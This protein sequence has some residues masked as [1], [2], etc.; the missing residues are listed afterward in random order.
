MTRRN[1]AD[2][3]RLVVTVDL[4]S[5]SFHILAARFDGGRLSVVDRLR[6]RIALAAGLDDEG[7]LT[8]EMQDAALGC[9]RRFGQRLRDVPARNVRAVGTNTLRAAKNSAQFLPR[10]ERALGHAIDVVPGREE[11]R[12][13]YLGVCHTEP[14]AAGRRLVCD[15]GGGSTE[16]TLG[17]RFDPLLAECLYMGCV[18]WTRRHFDGGRITRKRFREAR[19]AARLEVQT[20]VRTFR[21]LGWEECLGA[22]GTIRTIADALRAAGK[23]EVAGSM[24]SGGAGR[25]GEAITA[26]GLEWL[27]GRVLAAGRADR[28]KIEGI[29]DER[30]GVIAG[31]LAILMAVFDGMGIER[32][33]VAQGGLREG[34]LWDLLGRIRHEDVRDRTIRGFAA[35]YRV[36][37]EQAARVER[38]ALRLL[39][40]AAES[41]G[42]GRDDDARN[43]LAWAAQLHEV[44]LAVTYSGHHKHGAYLL[45]NSDMPGF[46][47]REQ[48][49]LSAIV[50]EHR[51][52]VAAGAFDVLPEDWRP[53]AV[54]LTLLLRLAVRLH[55]SRTSRALPR[56][57]CRFAE[58]RVSVTFPP[59]WLD[60]HP[61]TRADLEE[62]AA[63]IRGCGFTLRVK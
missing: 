12:L 53:R 60:R 62:E 21:A 43:I 4:G 55:R 18:S 5:N 7:N 25:A 31:G 52:G 20:I 49:V 29:D 9:L 46:S 17:E 6:E 3:S 14:D 32:M 56:V 58:D 44:G 30:A 36:D 2:A 26:E 63:E 10:F 33:R 24:A 13:S 38:T 59:G 40:D 47:R 61:L 16:I 57:T 51:R 54:R 19:I 1:A 39:G 8:Q 28:I 27:L 15:I 41:W 23:S 50:H 22:S 45:R 42:L 11:A 34:V 35:R 48:D 37:S